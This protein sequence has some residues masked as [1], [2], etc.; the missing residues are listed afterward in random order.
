MSHR[1]PLSQF[2]RLTVALLA[3][4][5]ATAAATSIEVRAEDARPKAR[6]PDAEQRQPADSA[7]RRLPTDSVTRHRI[8]LPG[9][10]LSFTATAG[11]IP[12][13]N[14]QGR[15]I[16]EIAYIAYALDGTEPRQRPVTFA[17]NGG[18]GSASSWL[19]VGNFGPWRLQI[20]EGSISPSAP[21][22]LEPNGE[23]WLDF[24]DLVFIDPVGTGYSHIVA[25]SRE[26][27]EDGNRRGS[28]STED[29]SRRHF[30]SVDGD[31]ESISEF[32]QKWLEK[33]GRLTS[34][35][36]LVGESYG[37]FRGPKIARKL[38][39][40]YGVGLNALVL[41]SPVLDFA[42]RRNGPMPFVSVL[43]SLAAASFERRGEAVSRERLKSIEEYA[44]TD[45]MNDLMRGPR[46]AAAVD[47]T[48]AKVAEIAG[49]PED[50]VRRYGARISGS[51]YNREVNRPEGKTASL[52][53]ASI[54]GLSENPTSSNPRDNDPLTA[55]LN[56]PLTTAMLDL[57]NTRLGWRVDQRYINT[58]GDAN[59][60]WNWGNSTSSP[61]SLG[62]M[63]EALALDPHLRVIVAHGF[64][65]LVTPYFGSALVLD[66]LPA[67]GDVQRVKA[68]VYPGGHMFYTRDASRKAFR[69]DALHLMERIIIEANN[70]QK[71]GQ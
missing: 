6:P 56:A 9:R 20:D 36:M 45:Y 53:D 69:E 57:Y 47:R 64:T 25:D 3:L 67:H 66:Q 39:E 41:I 55:A 7:S 60:A 24:T 52:Y 63:R 70:T 40:K 10:S 31:V 54:K 62:D 2:L 28:G 48:V 43:P 19:H 34:P 12:L 49:L 11:S 37:G 50:T 4:A 33:S 35:K 21:V 42:G 14:P 65:D 17:F 5:A 16:A 13:A 18:P 27:G 22:V 38:Q 32:M 30:W 15:V 68:V 51:T 46:D 29:S 61:E 23:T 58:N 44:R 71:S 26:G 1:R 59:R 8:E